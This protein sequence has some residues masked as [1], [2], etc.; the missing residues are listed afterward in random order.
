MTTPKRRQLG[1]SK[2]FQIRVPITLMGQFLNVCDDNA[3]NASAVLRQLMERWVRQEL[4]KRVRAQRSS[5]GV[6]P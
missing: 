4:S 5:N 3:Q 1:A 6:S 2:P